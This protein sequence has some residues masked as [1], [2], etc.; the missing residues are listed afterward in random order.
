MHCWWPDNPHNQTPAHAPP[1]RALR[2]HQT[3]VDPEA[4]AKRRMRKQQRKAAGKR[5][6]LDHVRR[7]RAAGA[8]VKNK[9]GAQRGEGRDRGG[10]GGGGR[11]RGGRGRR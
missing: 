2:P 3:L 1:P 5:K 4:A 8:V 9:R 10:G 7:L 6:A 11:D